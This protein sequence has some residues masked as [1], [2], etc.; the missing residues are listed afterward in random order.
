MLTG[1]RISPSAA[2]AP[3]DE[4]DCIELSSSSSEHA[5]PE[6]EMAS[7]DTAGTRVE[8][9]AAPTDDIMPDEASIP[10]L[11]RDEQLY[12]GDKTNPA[13]GALA[14]QKQHADVASNTASVP[15]HQSS[16]GDQHGRSHS[17]STSARPHKDTS[18]ESHHSQSQQGHGVW[19]GEKATTWS[20]ATPWWQARQTQPPI[21]QPQGHPDRAAWPG[22]P[23]SQHSMAAGGQ[24]RGDRQYGETY[25]GSSQPW[26]PKRPT[27]EVQ[28]E[29]SDE[30]SEEFNIDRCSSPTLLCC[31]QCAYYYQV[32]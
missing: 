4:A 8:A 10:I 5:A 3:A 25:C 6:D 19:P 24:H 1:C 2:E 29:S 9:C 27:A 22:N 30:E 14:K 21:E 32:Y 23:C 7:A 31:V 13:G 28:P 20:A 17:T 26:P 11:E 15:Q 16:P 18:A 12:G